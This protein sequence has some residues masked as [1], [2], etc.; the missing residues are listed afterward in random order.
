M[1]SLI[2]ENLTKAGFTLPAAPAPVA[3]YVP[4]IRSGNLVH[5]SGQ[6]SKI[7]DSEVLGH[8]GGEVSLE[9]GIRAAQLCALNLFSQLKA[10]CE[11]ELSRAQRCLRLGG[12]VAATPAFTD[13]PKVI[14]GASDLM[15]TAMGERGRHARA[16]VGVASLPL[17][18]AVEID[19]LFEVS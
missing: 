4:W 1:T 17:G 15:V 5:I 6:I 8:L 2:E 3:N 19:G 10:A 14:N 7:G 11:G 12:F 18:V 16:A 13:H 9:D